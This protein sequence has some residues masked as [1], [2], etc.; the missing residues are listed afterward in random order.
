MRL[1]A[2]GAGVLVELL[3]VAVGA[4]LPLPESLQS[5]AALALLTVGFAGGYVAGRFAGDNWRVGIVH[6]LLA[7]AI[8]GLTLAVVLPALAGLL[9]AIEGALAG[10]AAGTVS[11]EPP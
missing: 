10:G 8:G 1:E 6:G 9:L 2:V 4:T 11:V 3:A 7:G 5:T